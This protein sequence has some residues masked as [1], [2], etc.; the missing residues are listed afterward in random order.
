M[1]EKPDWRLSWEAMRIALIVSW[2]FTALGSLMLLPSGRESSSGWGE[3]YGFIHGIYFVFGYPLTHIAYIF[4]PR[5]EIRP[6]DYWWAMPLLNFLFFAQWVFWTQLIVL[7]W[8]IL[9]RLCRWLD[10]KFPWGESDRVA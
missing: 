9:E 8:R 4:R 1:T 10:E 6:S 5:G 3:V 2:P 7:G